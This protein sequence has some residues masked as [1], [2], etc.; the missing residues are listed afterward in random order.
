[1]K[2]EKVGWICCL[3]CWEINCAKV[4]SIVEEYDLGENFNSN[5]HSFLLLVGAYANPFRFLLI[6]LSTTAR[7]LYRGMP[8]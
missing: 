3:R 8:T 1:M 6:E 7:R 4:T 2:R 5:V